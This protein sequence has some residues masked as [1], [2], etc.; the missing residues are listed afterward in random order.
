MDY[1]GLVSFGVGG[2]IV[3]MVLWDLMAHVNFLQYGY[4]TGPLIF[5]VLQNCFFSF[6]GFLLVGLGLKLIIRDIKAETS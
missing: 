3:L 2:A 5:F 4:E 6:I 1:K